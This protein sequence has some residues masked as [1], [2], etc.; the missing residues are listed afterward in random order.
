MIRVRD[1]LIST[2]RVRRIRR[3]YIHR[4]GNVLPLTDTASMRFGRPVPREHT[5]NHRAKSMKRVLL[6]LTLKSYQV[7]VIKSYLTIGIR[8]GRRGDIRS[9]VQARGVGYVW[10]MVY[11][12]MSCFVPLYLDYHYYTERIK[13]E[14]KRVGWW[15]W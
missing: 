10:C 9:G 12:H 8:S 1:Q 3:R 13:E 15:G 4:G 14:G 5:F 11:D 6:V 2:I 7:H